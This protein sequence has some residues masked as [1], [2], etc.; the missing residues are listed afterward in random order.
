MS[1]LVTLRTFAHKHELF[2]AID[3]SLSTLKKTS[4]RASPL[5]QRKVGRPSRRSWSEQGRFRFTG[6]SLFQ[7][8]DIRYK[9]D[10]RLCIRPTFL[11][12]Q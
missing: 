9:T 12:L 4:R 7:K 11:R 2:F 6:Y 1:C 3:T 10:T 8:A 5:S